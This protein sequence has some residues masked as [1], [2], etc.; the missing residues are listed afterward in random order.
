MNTKLI[1]ATGLV[2]L[3]DSLNEYDPVEIRPD[4]PLINYSVD[5]HVSVNEKDSQDYLDQ[6]FK[7]FADRDYNVLGFWIGVDNVIIGTGKA[8]IISITVV[9]WMTA[10]E[11]VLNP[12]AKIPTKK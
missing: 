11:A 3:T 6:R 10:T 1:T 2:Q 8:E 7:W 5:A 9:E 12:R 4:T